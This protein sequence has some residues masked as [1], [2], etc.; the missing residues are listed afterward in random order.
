LQAAIYR[1]KTRVIAP[2]S[3]TRWQIFSVEV[4]ELAVGAS[5]LLSFEALRRDTGCRMKFSSIRNGGSRANSKIQITRSFFGAS[6]SS[7]ASPEASRGS[8]MLE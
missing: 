1:Q 5:F 7:E 2:Q 8:T 4:E 3:L 6:E